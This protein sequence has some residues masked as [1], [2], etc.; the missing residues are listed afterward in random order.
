MKKKEEE[1]DVYDDA[2]RLHVRLSEYLA[3]QDYE[4]VRTCLTISQSIGIFFQMFGIWC[5]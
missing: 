3:R 1:L 5:W 2:L 4:T